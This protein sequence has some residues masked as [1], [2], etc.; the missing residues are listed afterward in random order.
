MQSCLSTAERSF[1]GF[2]VWV[3]FCFFGEVGGTSI[4]NSKLWVKHG[5]IPF[6][7]CLITYRS[8]LMMDIKEMLLAQH[9]THCKFL[10]TGILVHCQWQSIVWKL[11]SARIWQPSDENITHC[12]PNQ[13]PNR[14]CCYPL[15]L[16]VYISSL[17]EWIAFV[18]FTEVGSADN[19]AVTISLTYTAL[20]WGLSFC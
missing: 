19:R 9:L 3:F 8:F 5:Y 15:S 4:C 10:F 16:P 2:G 17:N 6:N 14:L 1:T 18:L 20:T 12:L 13:H 11:G 7:I